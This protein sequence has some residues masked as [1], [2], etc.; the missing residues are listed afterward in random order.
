MR[1]ALASRWQLGLYV[2]MLSAGLAGC[3]GGEPTSPPA[4]ESLVGRMADT[5]YSR[6]R[7]LPRVNGYGDTVRMEDFA[8]QFIW[9]H[10]AA[11]WCGDSP[12]QTETLKRTDL[13][14]VLL[15][16]M[17][18]EMGG[19]GHPATTDTAATWADRF[20]LPPSRTIAADLTF[21]SLPKHVLYSPE[22]QTLLEHT[23]YLS[24]EAIRSTFE[25]YRQDWVGWKET[26]E[27]AAWMQ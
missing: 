2:V 9:A 26:G 16:I 19:Y 14:A 13:E 11:P 15:T 21:M 22:G 27:R 18:S 24:A 17:T 23:G 10:Y 20:N 4:T 8:G 12:R 1:H 5:S 6:I 25:R 3:G 7:G